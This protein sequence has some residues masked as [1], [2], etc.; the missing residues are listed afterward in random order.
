M[1]KAREKL[2]HRE[3]SVGGNVSA[4]ITC[5]EC[6]CV[7]PNMVSV[8]HSRQE[9]SSIDLLE[10]GVISR[11]CVPALFCLLL[12]FRNFPSLT[13]SSGEKFREEEKSPESKS[14][15]MGPT[16][17][18]RPSPPPFDFDRTDDRCF[19]CSPF[20]QTPRS[21]VHFYALCIPTMMYMMT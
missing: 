16:S 21:D 18:P 3:R 7:H 11:P 15:K 6:K 12:R 14:S 20:E 17:K 13:S 10:V 2:M 19:F 4:C 8:H 1:R 5:K 9:S